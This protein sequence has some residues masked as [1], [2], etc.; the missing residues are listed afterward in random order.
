MKRRILFIFLV[1]VLFACK[2]ETKDHVRVQKF[3][4]TFEVEGVGGSLRADIKDGRQISSGEEIE[5]GKTIVFTTIP[6][7]DY[8]VEKWSGAEENKDN[9][10]I[11]TLLVGMESHVKVSFS[12]DVTK[13]VSIPTKENPIV[14][15]DVTYEMPTPDDYWKGVFLKDRKVR[16]SPYLLGK[17]Q[18]TYELWY[19]VR[20]WAIERGYVFAHNGWEGSFVQNGGDEPTEKKMHP[21]TYISWRDAVVWCNAYTEM[22]NGNTDN[23]VYSLNGEIVKK[24][25]EDQE[26][27]DFDKNIV[28]DL[29]KTGFRL[30]TE[31]EWEYVARYQGENSTNAEK[32][33]DIYLTKVNSP[34]GG[35][36]YWKNQA[37]TERVAWFRK[38]SESHTHPVGEKEA[39]TLKLYDMSGNVYEWCWDWYHNNPAI[40]DSAYT[41]N[42]I[43]VNPKGV[44]YSSEILHRINRGGG[45]AG[46]Q[47][48]CIVGYRYT[49][50]PYYYSKDL[51]FRLAKTIK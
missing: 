31:A 13:L 36:D 8:T 40:N 51:G 14:G 22:T 9:K 44:Q 27:I 7:D 25:I 48:H 5:K 19:K 15:I 26:Y 18:V 3:K 41:E 11:A 1:C 29:T 17:Y 28:C 33:G 4:I 42:D 30:P 6:D 43:V 10:N 20:I 46:N 37:D 24:S 16:L 34:S 35:K 21:V 32:Y 39:N 45:Y 47:R 49:S 12:K 23:C 50:A 2:T 38:N